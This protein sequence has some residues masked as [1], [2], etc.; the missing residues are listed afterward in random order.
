M[1]T[2][3][4]LQQ[5]ADAAEQRAA[6]LAAAL[7]ALTDQAAALRTRIA[8]YTINDDMLLMAA[9]QNKLGFLDR[10]IAADTPRA[11]A[12]QQQAQQARA[13]AE[14]AES[15]A[16]ALERRLS[17]LLVCTAAWVLRI[18]VGDWKAR[19]QM[20]IDHLRQLGVEPQIARA[21]ARP[22]LSE[23][24]VLVAV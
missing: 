9:D 17:D 12:D 20:T 2:V 23:D 14:R 7:A 16:W 18:E 13:A 4:E 24:V 1:K 15:E 11:Q 8:A 5:A 22:P 10:Q 3:S 19:I 21:P 6:T